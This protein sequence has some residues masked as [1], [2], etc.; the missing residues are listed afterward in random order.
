MSCHLSWIAVTGP[1]KDA[2]LSVLGL[3][4]VSPD[5]EPSHSKH[6]VAELPSG[7]VVILAAD[8]NYPTPARMSAVSVGGTAL[9]CS[10][11]ERTMYSVTRLYE[12]GKAVWSVD[13]DGGQ[14]GVYHL[15]VAGAPPPELAVIRSRL[16]AEQDRAGGEEAQVDLVFDVPTELSEVLCGYRF[17]PQK[18]G[19]KFRALEK[20]RRKGAN[21]LA[22]L[23]RRN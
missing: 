22:R 3:A 1:A 17:D 18:D 19:P 6:E 15:D 13:H 9:A 4:E 8:F 16:L 10:I 2:I 14:E 20:T 12:D 7:W 11:D 5:V 23:F 21:W